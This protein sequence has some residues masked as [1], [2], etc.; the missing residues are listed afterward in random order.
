MTSNIV[1]R[2]GASQHSWAI[3]ACSRR[4]WLF[5]FLVSWPVLG[6]AQAPP[7]LCGFQDTGQSDTLF[8]AAGCTGNA[9]GIEQVDTQGWND[10]SAI[11]GANRLYT[12]T[13]LSY[14]CGRGSNGL[15]CAPLSYQVVQNTGACGFCPDCGNSNCGTGYVGPDCCDQT[16]GRFECGPNN[17]C[18]TCTNTCISPGTQGTQC[19]ATQDCGSGLICTN[20]ACATPSGIPICG[21]AGSNC[22]AI[23]CQPPNC[24]GGLGWNPEFCECYQFSTP[25]VIDTDGSGFHLTS[26]ENGIRFDFFGNEK[27]IQIAWTAPG[28]TNGWLALDRNG[29]GNINS[30]KDLFGNVT[31]QP[32]S[33]N[34]N[35]FLALAVFDLQENGG[36]GDGMI[37]SQDAIWPKLL[38]WI[39]SNHDGISQP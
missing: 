28:S 15:S 17:R 8:C 11:P 36:N 10:S 22:S 37:D 39:D 30:G 3:L 14:D 24:T 29:D 19:C 2:L 34:P 12:Y 1:L 25:I 5:M 23:Q 18:S 32:P 21:P 9:T 13:T 31:A 4:L 16:N 6:S 27:R 38:V 7:P 20:G 33:D 26:A 35:G